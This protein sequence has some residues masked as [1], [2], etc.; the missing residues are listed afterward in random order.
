[1][2]DKR[3]VEKF[4]ESFDVG[5]P[6]HVVK[7]IKSGHEDCGCKIPV[8]LF[9]DSFPQGNK[10]ISMDIQEIF[11][12]EQGKR[13]RITVEEIPIGNRKGNRKFSYNAR[14]YCLM[15][16]DKC[17]DDK[18]CFKHDKLNE[19]ELKYV[20]GCDKDGYWIEG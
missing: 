20:V 12:F 10:D 4:C 15:R 14:N 5:I 7:S 8:P 1:M 19:N 3:A 16:C 11:K 6:Q 13:Y 17:Q 9:C 18:I 2:R